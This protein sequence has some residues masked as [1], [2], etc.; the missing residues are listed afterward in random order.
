MSDATGRRGDDET[1]VYDVAMFPQP[2]P[3]PPPAP[4]PPAPPSQPPQRPATT[5]Q[6]PPATGPYA[7]PAYAPPAVAPVAPSM[8]VRRPA[9][10]P[11]PAGWDQRPPPYDTS[12]LAVL[13]A[14]TLLVVGIIGAIVFGFALAIWDAVARLSLGTLIQL[15]TVESTRIV[16]IT[17]LIAAIVQTVAAIGVFAHRG[18]ARLVSIAISVPGTVVGTLMLV[19]ATSRGLMLESWLGGLLLAAFGFSFFGLIA[20]N[21]HFR[22]V[23]SRY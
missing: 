5:T 16:L 1:D 14:T 12:A 9:A 13:A 11:W 21:S 3:A 8:A 19:A 6:Q 10:P 23:A 18:W 17:L 7:A 15:Q 4:L 2:R 20:G 22:R